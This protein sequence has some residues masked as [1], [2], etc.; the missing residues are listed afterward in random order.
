MRMRVAALLI[1]ILADCTFFTASAVALNGRLQVEHAEFVLRLDDGRTL[2][3][4]DLVG[5]TLRLAGAGAS[6]AVRISGIV[7]DRAATG[8]RMVLYRLSSAGTDH[9][10]DLCQPDFHGRQAGFPL[11]DKAGGFTFVCTSGAAGKCVLMGYRPWNNSAETPLRALHRACVHMLRADYGGD[12]RPTTRDGTAVDI[13][14]RFQI[15]LPAMRQDMSLEAAWSEDGAVCVA[16][17][18]I[19]QNMTLGALAERYDR[20]AGHLGPQSCTEDAMR[21]FPAVLLFNRSAGSQ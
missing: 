13:Y 2:G 10:V 21:A 18:R 1:C 17:P 9:P 19:P 8:G 11:P 5:L 3:G 7:E 15:Q 12:D 14:D 20:L 16:H 4:Q 6:G